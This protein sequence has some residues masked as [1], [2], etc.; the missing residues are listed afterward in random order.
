MVMTFRTG[1]DLPQ[2]GFRLIHCVK[3]A[4]GYDFP[5]PVITFPTYLYI[6]LTFCSLIFSFFDDFLGDNGA[7]RWALDRVSYVS[8]F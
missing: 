1:Y 8:S 7:F 5:Q 6:V 4:F 3:L 2:V